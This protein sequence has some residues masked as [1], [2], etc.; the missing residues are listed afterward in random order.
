MVYFLSYISFTDSFSSR[1]FF[2]IS[3]NTS[4]ANVFILELISSNEPP[5][6]SNNNAISLANLAW[7]STKSSST[8]PKSPAAAFTLSKFVSISFS[9]RIYCNPASSPGPPKISAIATPT[10]ALLSGSSFNFSETLLIT[11]KVV[12]SPLRNSS[13]TSLELIPIL[14]K[15]AAVADVI[16][17]IRKFPSLITSIPLSE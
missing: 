14:S 3:A 9:V 2:I 15:A 4:L 17:R 7:L 5:V 8:R 13:N 12:V 10:A 6:L 16:S 11:S 1:T